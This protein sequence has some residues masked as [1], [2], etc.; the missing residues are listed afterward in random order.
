LSLHEQLLE[1][2]ETLRL[3]A[4]RDALTGCFNRRGILELL[5]R[6]LARARRPGTPTSI[7]LG[8]LDHFKAVNDGHGHAGGDAVLRG[9]AQ[10]LARSLREYDAVGRYG[11][12]EFLLVLPQCDLGNAAAVAERVRSAVADTPVIAGGAD[13]AA[14][15]SLGVALCAGTPDAT[16]IE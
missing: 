12:E 5:E 14:T 16:A 11:G 15:V 13:V 7:V 4:T 1:T 9:V 8:D 2:Q 10:R 6:E 3:Q